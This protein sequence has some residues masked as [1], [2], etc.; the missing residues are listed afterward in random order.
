MFFWGDPIEGDPFWGTDSLYTHTLQFT[1]E[2]EPE[3]VLHVIVTADDE[4]GE[5]L[6]MLMNYYPG[7][8]T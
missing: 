6:E 8:V 4:Q 7:E 1:Y 2:L 3:E 5:N